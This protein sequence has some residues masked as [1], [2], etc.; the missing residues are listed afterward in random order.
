MDQAAY[1]LFER[2]EDSHWWLRG[3][4]TL[5]FGLLDAMLPRDGSVESVDVGCGYGAMLGEL[6]RYGPATGV[7]LHPEA[8]EQC[9]SRGFERVLEGSAYELPIAD[10]SAGLV[11]FFDCL[12]HLDDDEAALR[13]AR[14]V[15]RPGGMIAV[16]G[17]AFNLLYANNDRVAH[18]RRRYTRAELR[19]KLEAAGFEPSKATY[20]NTL[21]FP[22]IL[23]VVLLKKLKER[24][25][26]VADDPTTNLTHPV[27]GPV[28]ETL[29]RVFAAELPLLRRV[30]FPVGH[31]VF[32]AGVKRT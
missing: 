31:S 6:E 2:L 30:S 29:Y 28:N 22:I 4:R 20:V 25:F 16:S 5:Y 23:P 10:E 24:L 7:E 27:A 17:P 21:L 32:V 14:R 18:H 26:P 19:R 11:T 13:E 9:R 15:L 8:V 3:R 12:E 1:E